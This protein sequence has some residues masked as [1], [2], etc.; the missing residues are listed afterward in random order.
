MTARQVGDQ[1]GDSGM[2]SNRQVDHDSLPPHRTDHREIWI[3]RRLHSQP[4]VNIVG[5]VVAT[6]EQEGHDHDGGSRDLWQNLLHGWN[7]IEEGGA[8]FALA[9]V[10]GEPARECGR[11]LTAAGVP[12]GAVPDEQNSRIVFRQTPEP[13]QLVDPIGND[14]PQARMQPERWSNLQRHRRIA[15]AGLELAR[16]YLIGVIAGT[17]EQ[18]DYDHS[19]SGDSIERGGK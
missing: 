14:V 13:A 4:P 3:G 9:R 19:L 7:V 1:L 12:R 11:R 16:K 10:Q 15:A 18:W 8:H 6:A 17:G 2:M 5:G